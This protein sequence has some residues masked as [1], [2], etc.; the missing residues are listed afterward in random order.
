MLKEPAGQ[1]QTLLNLD[2]KNRK[3]T[4][5]EGQW[6][7][8]LGRRTNGA[9]GEEQSRTYMAL[10]NINTTSFFDK[11]GCSRGNWLANYV[12]PIA[13]TLPKYEDKIVLD[14]YG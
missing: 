4:G 9:K 7:K 12:K 14:L 13:S 6:T 8:D 1:A 11:H 2:D 10:K 5:K 3:T